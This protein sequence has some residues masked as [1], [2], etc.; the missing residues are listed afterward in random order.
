MKI[1]YSHRTRSADGQYV[2]IRELTEA[3]AA[4]GCEVVIAGP[5]SGDAKALD[6]GEGGGMKRFLPGP[7]Y[8]CAEYGYSF[9][10]YRRLAALAAETR[11]DVLYERY[12]LFYHAGAW[13][14]RRAGLPMLLEVNAPLVDERRAHGGL[15]L[16]DF[17]RRSE[18]AIWRAADMV[19]PVSNALADYVRAAG[20]PGDRIEVIHNGVGADFLIERDGW[21]VRRRYGL[22]DKLVLGFTGFVREWHRVD[23]V[24][25]FL[26]AHENRHLAFLLVGDGPVRPG[27]ETLAAELGVSDRVRFAGVVQREHL[28]DHVAAFDVALQPAVTPYA[29][30]LKLFEYMALGK[31]IIAPAGANIR[32]A[33]RGG[34]EALLFGQEEGGF[35]RA[36]SALVEDGELRARLGSAARARLLRDDLT[37]A[38]NARRVERL[39]ETLLETP[40]VDP[41]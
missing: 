5:D 33:L 24:I 14:K 8:E 36:L 26:A 18:A 1:L 11:P 35:D 23:R 19:L 4:R 13:L 2:H 3:L 9:L 25:R 29:S 15:A 7:L 21:A 30:P 27:L 41:A 37:W 6:A 32:E 31:A 16:K 40:H 17:A 10:G 28:A 34:E 20:V 22:E 38:G 39:A 12:N